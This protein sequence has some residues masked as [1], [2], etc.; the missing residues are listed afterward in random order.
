MKVLTGLVALALLVPVAEASAQA[1]GAAKGSG[2]GMK[3]AREVTVMAPG[4]VSWGDAPA[5]LP[6]GAKLAVLDGNPMAGGL[7]TIRLKMPDGY[8]I[9]PHSHPTDEH[10]T[11]LQGN[12]M[13]GMGDKFDESMMNKSSEGTFANIPAGMHHY[14]KTDGETI[15]QIHGMGPFKIRYVNKADDP[16]GKVAG[17]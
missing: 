1:K 7:F 9:P 4:A 8:V 17:K 15:L 11:V 5:F 10:V 6:A 2:K 13:V 14:A 16:R 3:K 12:I